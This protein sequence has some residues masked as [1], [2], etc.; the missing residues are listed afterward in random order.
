MHLEVSSVLEI[1]PDSSVKENSA[2][3]LRIVG[4]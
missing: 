4:Q 1:S 2:N 3:G